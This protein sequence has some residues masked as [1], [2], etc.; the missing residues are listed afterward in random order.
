MQ[1]AVTAK[2][3]WNPQTGILATSLS[4]AVDTKDV[5]MWESR[6]QSALDS[7]PS[8]SRFKLLVNFYGLAPVSV[9]AHKRYRSVIPATLAR[10]GWRVGYLDMFPEA[11][12]LHIVAEREVRC[13]AA[14][15]VH[16]DTYKIDEYDRRF[17]NATERFFTN[18]QLAT[19]WLS[20]AA[21]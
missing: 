9:E 3:E 6:L 19:E 15:H 14:V 18:V 11:D 16:Q 17:G 10:Y 1:Q 2:T 5:E 20:A 7:L 8:G 13:I 21:A 4:G 12:G